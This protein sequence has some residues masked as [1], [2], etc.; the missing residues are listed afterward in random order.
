MGV[1]LLL[2]V[3]VLGLFEC[4]WCLL[5]LLPVVFAVF[6]GLELEADESQTFLHDSI[7]RFKSM[8]GDKGPPELLDTFLSWVFDC[9]SLLS[10]DLL[11]VLD[12][13]DW[14]YFSFWLSVLVIELMVGFESATC[15]LLLLLDAAADFFV[16]SSFNKI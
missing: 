9:C 11:F 5:L 1:G 3:L 8:L 6:G 7:L 14:L 16:N 2:A 10:L 13:S 4:S 15:L 12:T